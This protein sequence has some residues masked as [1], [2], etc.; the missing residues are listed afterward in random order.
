MQ[1]KFALIRLLNDELKYIKAIAINR[2]YPSQIV[3]RAFSRYYKPRS[4]DLDKPQ[5]VIIMPFYP[6]I[7]YQ[8]VRIL[9][10]FNF[11]TVFLP[12]NKL[13]FTMTKDRIVRNWGIYQVFCQ[14][15]M[16]YIG[17]TKRSLLIRL[18]EHNNCVKKQEINRSSI[19]EHSWRFG[20]RFDFDSATIIQKCNSPSELDFYETFHIRKN[21]D[22]LVND[23][24]VVPT[25][26]PA[27]LKVLGLH[28]S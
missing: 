14:C 3:D 26:H 2:G 15:G 1:L 8:L 10:K 28:N 7:S 19:A 16:F 13:K 20:H 22:N 4:P 17:Q 18:K 12:I 21:A 27:W 6:K 24:S 5:N 23:L 11:N 25:I 9:K